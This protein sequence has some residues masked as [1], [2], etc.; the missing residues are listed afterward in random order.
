LIVNGDLEAAKIYATWLPYAPYLS[1][2]LDEP[3]P[4]PDVFRLPVTRAAAQEQLAGI[5]SRATIGF[6]QNGERLVVAALSAA[7]AFQKLASVWRGDT[8]V[9]P[10][11][12]SWLDATDSQK[13]FAALSA[14]DGPRLD[15]QQQAKAIDAIR[16]LMHSQE[17]TDRHFRLPQLVP[18]IDRL[19]LTQSF[20]PELRSLTRAFA[21]VAIAAACVL[22][23]K[24]PPNELVELSTSISQGSLQSIA[25]EAI[26]RDA[27]GELVRSAP[28]AWSSAAFHAATQTVPPELD[29]AI[30][31]LE[32]L[33]VDERRALAQRLAN[34]IGQDWELPW[35]TSW[36]ANVTYRPSDLVAQLLFDAGVS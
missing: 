2:M 26:D 35:L 30:P 29:V 31:I 7:R 22:R 28:G 32:V 13:C 15:P 36:R 21:P 19:G 17:E 8:V 18:H 11:L 1:G 6:E 24:I 10:T 33:P 3:A 20:L 16:R 27:F 9:T 14:L 4:D 12:V 5:V 23:N 34:H 25:F